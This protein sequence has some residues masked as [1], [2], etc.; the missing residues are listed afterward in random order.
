MTRFHIFA[1]LHPGYGSSWSHKRSCLALRSGPAGRV[2]KGLSDALMRGI[3]GAFHNVSRKYPHLYV[4]EFQ[5]RYNNHLNDD[6][7]RTAIAGA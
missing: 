5:F 2:S 4:A 1:A 7:F 3:V 6:I